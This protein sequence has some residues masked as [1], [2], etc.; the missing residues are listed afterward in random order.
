MG[1]KDARNLRSFL[2]YAGD[3]PYRELI[4]EQIQKTGK[5]DLRRAGV[6]EASSL[7]DAVTANSPGTLLVVGLQNRQVAALRQ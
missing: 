5:Q 4:R 1:I 2:A 7:P 6:Y 3:A